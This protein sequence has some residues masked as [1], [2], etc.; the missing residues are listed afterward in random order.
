MSGLARQM[1]ERKWQ[2]YMRLMC[3][4]P[5]KRAYSETGLCAEIMRFGATLDLVVKQL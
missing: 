5:E 1:G 2:T 4:T 3:P